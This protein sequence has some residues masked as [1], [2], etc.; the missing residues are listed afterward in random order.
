MRKSLIFL[1][2]LSTIFFYGCTHINTI[3]YP[4]EAMLV[5]KEFNL[6]R[7][8]SCS[9]EKIKYNS[10]LASLVT[11]YLYIGEDHAPFV[12]SPSYLVLKNGTIYPLRDPCDMNKVVFEYV[13]NKVKVPVGEISKISII[14]L[15]DYS[16]NLA[17]KIIP[18]KYINGE[19][20]YILDL[21]RSCSSIIEGNI[22]S[23]EMNINRAKELA[24][25]ELNGKGY[26]PVSLKEPFIVF[27][28]DCWFFEVELKP[29]M[30]YCQGSIGVCLNGTVDDRTNHC[31]KHIPN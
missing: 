20:Y 15:V 2:L 9:V 19:L 14:E 8:D 17:Y 31:I 7:V 16:N 28:R 11:V 24:I 18:T 1:L 23:G 12:V 6:T 26:T 25:N 4:K 21:N 27:H 30:F 13:W 22:S 3:T 5:I 29:Q 10:N